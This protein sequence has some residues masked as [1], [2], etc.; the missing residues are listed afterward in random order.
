MLLL[1]ATLRLNLKTKH[2]CE[3]QTSS[4]HSSLNI[5][6]SSVSETYMSTQT[7]KS[8]K[9]GPASDTSTDNSKRRG[10]TQ[11]R[12]SSQSE[13]EDPKIQTARRESSS[14]SPIGSIST[15]TPLT[16][17]GDLP[18]FAPRDEMN[19]IDLLAPPQPSKPPPAPRKSQFVPISSSTSLSAPLLPHPIREESELNVPP[20][21]WH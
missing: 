18:L 13:T 4:T 16:Q 19:Q 12:R 17:V 10:A 11:I 15:V 7:Q 14:L 3:D 6:V 8:K 1:Y 9:T 20:S 2:L 5:R 21:R